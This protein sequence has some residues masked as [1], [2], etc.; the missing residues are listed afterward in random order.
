MI[1]PAD[2]EFKP[3][4]NNLGEQTLALLQDKHVSP[5]GALDGNWTKEAYFLFPVYR[6]GTLQDAITSMQEKKEHFTAL[7]VLQ[8]L[9][10]VSGMAV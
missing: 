5:Q 6:E 4:W 1:S 8:I 3:Y 9:K 10:Q 7:E 2:H